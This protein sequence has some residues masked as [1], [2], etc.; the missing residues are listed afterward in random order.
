MDSSQILGAIGAAAGGSVSGGGLTA[1]VARWLIKKAFEQA[2]SDVDELKEKVDDVRLAI[3]KMN[4]PLE[5]VA[6]HDAIIR[7]HAEAIAY[8]EG[9]HDRRQTH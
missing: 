2:F 3:A 1:M 4:A 8:F 7:D 9:Q 5:M 6:K